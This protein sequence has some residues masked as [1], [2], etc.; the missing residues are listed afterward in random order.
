VRAFDRKVRLQIYERFVR[1]GRP[2]SADETA[3]ALGASAV[4]VEAAYRRLGDEHAIVL[5]PG[6]LDVWMANPLSAVPTPFR[7]EAGSRFFWANCI[8]DA[9]GILPMLRSDGLV[10]TSCPDCQEPMS[11]EVR[12]GALAPA[13]GMIHFAVPAGQWWNDIGFT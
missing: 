1:E 7:V 12:E 13:E 2:P 8:W 9:L 10:R 3:E 6:T 4:E 11:L 5:A